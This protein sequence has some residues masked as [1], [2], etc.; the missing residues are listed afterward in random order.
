M[1]DRLRLDRSSLRSPVIKADGTVVYEAVLSR[2]GVLDYK[3]DDGSWRGEHRPEVEVFS[4]KSMASFDGMALTDYHPGATTPVTASNRTKLNRGYIVPGSLR[5]DGMELIG[6]IHVTDANLIASINA[7]RTAVSLGYFQ[8]RIRKDGVASEDGKPFQWEQTNIEGNHVA[9]VDI[10]RAG[11]TARIRT[12]AIT[13]SSAESE[14]VMDEL[15]K[16]LADLLIANTELARRQMRIDALEVETGATKKSLATIE[17]ER[18]TLKERLVNSE[19][20][21]VDGEAHA[22]ENAR[23]RVRLEDTATKVL[24]VDG[25]MPDIAK[26]TD[27]KVQEMVIVK[28][29][30]K[31]LPAGKSADYVSARFDSLVDDLPART[32]REDAAIAIVKTAIKLNEDGAKLNKT[33]ADFR[34][35]MIESERNA[36]KS[37]KK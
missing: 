5:R 29:T 11:D 19:K 4:P 17:A 36:W 8:D 20:L 9:I 24:T 16:A 26:L 10:A 28:L 31:E 37:S 23:A 7:G 13:A 35:D 2:A 6:A 1:S 30:G 21:R 18:D 32:D 27:R 22:V 33:A 14:I 3:N 25:A 12:D 15:K 34:Q